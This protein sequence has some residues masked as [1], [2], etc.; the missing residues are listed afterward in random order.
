MAI[1]ILIFRIPEEAF[2]GL[3]QARGGE[4]F[5]GQDERKGSR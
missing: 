3:D 1:G 5:I 2:G 4:P